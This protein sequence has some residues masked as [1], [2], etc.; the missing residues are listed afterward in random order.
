MTTIAGVVFLLGA[1]ILAW[2]GYRSAADEHE[3][4]KREKE[5]RDGES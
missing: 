4:R 2:R 1:L 5:R 3:A